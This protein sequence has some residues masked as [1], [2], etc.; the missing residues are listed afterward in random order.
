MGRAA[1]GPRAL[2]PGRPA[3]GG[4][5]LPELLVVAAIVLVLLALSASALNNAILTA[6]ITEARHDLRQVQLGLYDYWCFHQAY[7]PTRKYCLTAKRALDC[8]LPPEL[9]EEGFLEGPVY[10][11]FNEGQTYRYTAIGPYRFNDGPPGGML[12]YY[13]PA[14]FPKPTGA[15]VG[16]V[17]P[18]TA[19]ASVFLW[20]AGPGGPPV[21]VCY[22][23][24]GVRPENPAHWYPAQANGILCY[25][26]GDGAWRY[27]Y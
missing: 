6:Q 16:T 24:D 2:C 20:S 12:R 5:T 26:F 27:S 21:T 10:D 23:A 18:K 14:D 17:D 11:V 3:R 9:W 19:P 22:S 1:T 4:F 25:Y 8:C 7:P 15:L 13:V